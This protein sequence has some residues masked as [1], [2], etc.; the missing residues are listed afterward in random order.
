MSKIIDW[1]VALFSSGDKASSKRVV[2]IAS[3]IV[4]MLWLSFDLHNHGITVLWADCFKTYI[5]MVIGG[6][7]LGT[8]IE[9]FGK[10]K[11]T[12]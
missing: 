6:F 8:G 12:E 11:D 2:F 9:T 4:S 7:I 10:K 1:V 3:A 5:G